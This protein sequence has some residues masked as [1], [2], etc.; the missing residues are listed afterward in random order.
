MYPAFV[1]KVSIKP[2]KV[3]VLFK[4]YPAFVENINQ[5]LKSNYF[6]RMYPAFVNY[7][8]KIT[9]MK[10]ASSEFVQK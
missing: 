7:T 4:V 3:T 6:V 1:I 2:L 9:K 5:I 8:E 10:S